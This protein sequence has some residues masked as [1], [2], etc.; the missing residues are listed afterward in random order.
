MVNEKMKILK[1]L[2]EGRISAEDAAK[3]L[4]GT[5]GGPS[6]AP[7]P[8][9][10]EPAGGYYSTASNDGFKGYAS[11]GPSGPSS[12]SGPRDR[13]AASSTAADLTRKLENLFNS[14]EP[15]LARIA[16][17]V[18]EKTGSA[19]DAI[20][21]SLSQ[22]PRPPEPA[23]PPHAPGAPPRTQSAARPVAAPKTRGRV[24]RAF[25]LK[26]TE[27]GSELILDGLNGQMLLK[28]YNGD[29]I[30][31]K[32]FY[33]AKRGNPVI[34][35]VALGNK[36]YLNYDENEFESV[37]VDAYIPESMFSSVRITNTMGP[38]VISTVNAADARFENQNGDIEISGFAA[39]NLLVETNNGNMRLSGITAERA[40]IDGFNGAIQAADIDASQMKMTTFNGGITMQVPGFNRHSEYTWGIEANNGK[41]N[42]ILPSSVDIGYHVRATAAL[43]E[44]R[45]GLTGLS[46]ISNNRSSAEAQSVNFDQAAKKVKLMLE[47][48]NAPIIVN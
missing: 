37:S 1:M 24:E 19:A 32:V 48:S 34:D 36:Y 26:I 5:S 18:V 9:P 8:P 10:S 38:L 2:E 45:L 29:K 33:T 20:A 41:M 11:S 43:S 23:R 40:A 27:T 16:E 28:G 13:R 39:K 22:P 21:K 44:V 30:T 25:E 14:V 6:P 31:A 42:M 17:T 47:T 35:L 46:Y 15:K 12:S 7:S 3:L 4:D